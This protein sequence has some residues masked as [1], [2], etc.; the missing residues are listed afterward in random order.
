MCTQNHS[1]SPTVP[2]TPFL[3]FQEI[4]K[5]ANYPSP[6]HP[7]PTSTATS[8][9]TPLN[10]H[11]IHPRSQHNLHQLQS[12]SNLGTS[13]NFQPKNPANFRTACDHQNTREF[14]IFHHS[15]RREFS[16]K[17]QNLHLRT[18]RHASCVKRCELSFTFPQF[19]LSN[20]FDLNHMSMNFRRFFRQL[21][22]RRRQNW[23][24]GEV[25]RN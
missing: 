24:V 5:P 13:T 25:G 20:L 7:P 14:P 19:S 2:I 10:S 21:I 23:V 6:N 11:S 3:K 9:K 18:S 12:H 22:A 17:P 1:N 8:P 4:S 16:S 15:N